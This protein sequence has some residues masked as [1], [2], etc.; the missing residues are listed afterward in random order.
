L[1]Q[2]GS[3]SPLPAQQLL[4][5]VALFYAGGLGAVGKR[6]AN[7][8]SKK[9]LNKNQKENYGRGNFVFTTEATTTQSALYYGKQPAFACRP[10]PA[11]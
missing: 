6:K 3:T 8:K 1:K 4:P 5:V 10:S 2:R 9:I 7:E 11:F